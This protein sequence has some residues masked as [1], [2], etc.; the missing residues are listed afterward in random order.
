M[1]KS[2]HHFCKRSPIA[3]GLR[4]NDGLCSLWLIF[5]F[6]VD[7]LCSLHGWR[8]LVGCNDYHRLSMGLLI[9][10]AVAVCTRLCPRAAGAA[11]AAKRNGKRSY[12]CN[13]R[14]DSDDQSYDLQRER[15][16]RCVNKMKALTAPSSS[17]QQLSELVAKQRS[18]SQQSESV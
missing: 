14:Y 9:L 13:A 15:F 3:T 7:G 5:W 18:P 17:S 1:V 6:C 4:F 8:W 12:T 10:V 11:E 16:I 2:V